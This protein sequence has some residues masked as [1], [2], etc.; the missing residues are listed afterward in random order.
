MD[1]GPFRCSCIGNHYGN[2]LDGGLEK[3]EAWKFLSS[4][5]ERERI[6]LQGIEWSF[7]NVK[8]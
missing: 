8:P 7:R 5:P 2:D 6:E 1:G 3:D 4:L